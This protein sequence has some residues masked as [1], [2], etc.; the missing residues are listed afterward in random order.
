M[1]TSEP[2]VP[3]VRTERTRAHTIVTFEDADDSHSYIVS[4]FPGVSLI[5]GASPGYA[6]MTGAVATDEE[7]RATTFWGGGV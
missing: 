7:Q 6:Y 2:A 1:A 3:R 4:F 5:P